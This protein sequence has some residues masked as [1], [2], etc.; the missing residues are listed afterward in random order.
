MATD[1]KKPTF[2]EFMN[3]QLVDL[4][5]VALPALSSFM[6]FS[7]DTDRK[8]DESKASESVNEGTPDGARRKQSRFSRQRADRTVARW[9]NELLA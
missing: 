6:E 4:T 1:D 3:S 8:S 7:K 9:N 5:K 2:S